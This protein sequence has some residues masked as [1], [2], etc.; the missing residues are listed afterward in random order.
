MSYNISGLP[1]WL[2][3]KES[4][5]NAEDQVQSLGQEDHL[6]K[7]MASHSSILAWRI[8]WTAEPD[9]LQYIR[10][11]RVGRDWETNTFTSLSCF[12]FSVWLSS[13]S[14]T[15]SRLIHVAANAY[16]IFNGWVTFHCIYVPHLYPF[17]LHYF[18]IKVHTVFF[19][20]ITL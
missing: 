10:L 15:I 6:E 14:I 7:G 8:P 1:W 3:N 19:I 17:L 13:L 18:V 16:F 12:Y 20:G 5:C 4:A 11:Q 2:S 9:G